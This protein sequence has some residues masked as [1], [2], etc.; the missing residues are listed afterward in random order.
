MGRGEGKFPFITFS[1]K[2]FFYNFVP[3]P[4]LFCLFFSF[5]SKAQSTYIP[6]VPKCLSPRPNWDPPSS[7]L[8]QASVSLPHEPKGGGGGH[9]RLR[10]GGC[11]IRTCMEKK[12][13]ITLS[14]LSVR[15]MWCI[16]WHVSTLGARDFRMY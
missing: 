14:T 9:T 16:L 8:P 2:H 12:P 13:I 4:A 7:P 5:L 3:F 11:P 15:K 1:Q 6:R 10:C